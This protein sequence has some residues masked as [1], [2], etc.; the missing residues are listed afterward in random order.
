MWIS[1][2]YHKLPRKIRYQH[3]EAWFISFVVLRLGKSLEL[4]SSLKL[5]LRING[6]FL[7]ALTFSVRLA[8][9]FYLLA[10][11]LLWLFEVGALTMNI[12][13]ILTVYNQIWATLCILKII[14]N[15]YYF[16]LKFRQN[17][18]KH[19]KKKA[20]K[21]MSCPVLL[22]T[23]TE[24]FDLMIPM[25]GLKHWNIP[26]V[27]L[28]ATGVISSLISLSMLWN[29]QSGKGKSWLQCLDHHSVF[30]HRQKLYL[31]LA[32]IKLL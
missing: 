4:L 32:G 15:L 3:N 2:T 6:W 22:D 12:S 7:L 1:I 27:I 31:S 30:C 25:N 14:K 26:D 16:N 21:L 28:G 23:V 18:H 17:Q 20:N 19:R 11:H 24:A 13:P 29:A 5:A 9:F 10:D 8:S